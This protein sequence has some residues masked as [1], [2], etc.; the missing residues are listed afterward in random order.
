MEKLNII[1]LHGF[2]SNKEIIVKQLKKV[3]N[4]NNEINLYS[5]DGIV[6]LPLLDNEPLDC[7]KKAHW[8]YDINSPLNVPKWGSY[9]S[10]TA[11]KF[12]VTE[13][14]NNFIQFSRSLNKVDGIIGYSQGGMFLDYLC[15]LN[16]E[17]KLGFTFKFAIFIAT[18]SFDDKIESFDIP[19]LHVYGYNDT[20]VLPDKSK[21]LIKKYNNA[22]EFTHNGK[23][24]LPSLSN[25]KKI[26]SQFIVSFR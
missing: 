12:C 2:T 4:I 8:L 22:V 15:R 21:N 18:C 7:K 1:C 20:V 26:I 10:L 6:D 5:I 24:V 16:H 11:T 13:S 17:N 14:L 23:H 19:S 9:E 25:F 3:L